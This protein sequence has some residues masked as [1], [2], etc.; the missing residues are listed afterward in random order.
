MRP[1]PSRLLRREFV[2]V[3]PFVVLVVSVTG[4][5]AEPPP[6]PGI[7]VPAGAGAAVLA[8]LQSAR[9]L[10]ESP[11]A[12]RVEP[13]L[14]RVMAGGF[15][16]GAP[17][18]AQ[19]R[20][21]RAPRGLNCFEVRFVSHSWRGAPVRIFG[22]FA[23]PAG[24][25]GPYPGLLLVHGGG[26]YATLERVTEAAREGY[27][28]F[29]I[30]L[31]GKGTLRERHSR[32]TGPDMTVQQIFTV[33]PE[34]TDNFLYHAVLAQ[35]RSV[36]FLRTRPEVDRERIGLVG[37][38]WGGATGLITTSLDRRVKCFVNLYGAGFLRGGSTWHQYLDRLPP[39]EVRAWEDNFDASRYVA[40]I[41]VPVLGVTGTNDNCYYLPRFMQTLRAI[42]PTPDLLLRPNLD[43]KVDDTAK[44]GYYR[45][46]AV[47]LKGANAASPPG[48]RS[49]RVGA[50]ER[51][52]RVY[53]QP[54]GRVAVSA[55]RIIHSEVGEV[56]WTNRRWKSARCVADRSRSWWSAEIPLTTQTMYVFANVHFADGSVV[57][58]PVHTVGLA[59]IG[60]RMFPM[61]APFMYDGPLLVEAHYLAGITGGT[62]QEAVSSPRI[63]LTRNGR[64]VTCDSRKVGALHY[65]SLRDAAEGLGG[66]VVWTRESPAIIISLPR[67][68]KGGGR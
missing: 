23:Y 54:A 30:D 40:D 25:G 41:R 58:T 28:A 67:L 33:K 18:Q 59:K 47:H 50:G 42:R 9:L 46:L 66:I 52:V 38:S 3:L 53:V 24:R 55:A 48:I 44:R 63:R 43:H 32:S 12:R 10:Y 1:A 22:Y 19:V 35:M 45:W 17:L 60:G 16:L 39:D 8:D 31:P 65:I 2:R 11:P 56:G 20:R 26:G 64:Q 5:S 27:A 34:M 49:L 7:S 13:V 36:T 62:A 14:R 51:A 15:D 21:I 29:A 4:C 68:G 37:V 61:H 6:P 57:S